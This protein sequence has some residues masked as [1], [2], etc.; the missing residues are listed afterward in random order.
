[1]LEVLATNSVKSVA[2]VRTES[3]TRLL[4]DATAADAIIA[5]LTKEDIEAPLTEALI[6]RG[7]TDVICTIGFKPTFV[8]DE[9]R[10]LAEAIDYCATL[11]LIAACEAAELP[12]RFV[13]VS[14]L[15]INSNSSSARILDS[16]L[17]G[18]LQQKRAAEAALRGS[19]LDWAVVRAGILLLKPS[20][21]Q[22]GLLLAG[23]DRWLGDAEADGAGLGGKVKCPSPFMASSGAVCSV[24]RAQLA[25]VCV[26][27]ITG[28]AAIY[29][30]LVVEVVAR[31]D[32]PDANTLRL[33]P[34]R[35]VTSRETS[36][37]AVIAS[38]MPR[39]HLVG[40]AVAVVTTVI[41]D[42]ALAAPK[43]ASDSPM[44]PDQ[45]CMAVAVSQTPDF[46]RWLREVFLAHPPPPEMAGCVRSVACRGTAALA[47]SAVV[48]SFFPASALADVR[49]FYDARGSGAWAA[50]R[51]DGLI[52]GSI[53]THLVDVTTVRVAARAGSGDG[54]A[55]G[56]RYVDVRPEPSAD[57]L[58]LHQGAG[59][60]F[61]AHGLSVG[62]PLW[63]SKFTSPSSD[64]EHASMGVTCSVAG[65]LLS[66][67]TDARLPGPGVLHVTETAAHAHALAAQLSAD[68]DPRV[69]DA[70]AL[71]VISQ[72]LYAASAEV[73]A[74]RRGYGAYVSP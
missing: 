24:T 29:S 39:R 50:A 3:A 62:Y 41:S 31:P 67:S 36:P 9:D 57:A 60:F 45:L 71:G 65:E 68:G 28:D 56:A 48:V 15:G 70:L 26:E 72:P 49:R 32:V 13:L 30:R 58:T 66:G 1:M 47:G 11:R 7:V 40:G 6:A 59:L 8:P 35:R 55:A 4:P 33:L 69:R 19:S 73:V 38:G 74:V 18:V 22:G 37:A 64:Q 25:R 43:T 54:S 44:D 23:E 34:P 21:S 46:S 2:G 14:S 52:T 27:A 12:G 63:L 5:D 51:R 53:H 10:R 17:G 16:S 42:A 61:G 20:S